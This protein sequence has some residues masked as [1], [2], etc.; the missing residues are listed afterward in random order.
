[1]LSCERHSQ[2]YNFG[3]SLFDP[4]HFIPYVYMHMIG[5]I[6]SF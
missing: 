6:L 2:D 1:M 5:T 3:W 4:G